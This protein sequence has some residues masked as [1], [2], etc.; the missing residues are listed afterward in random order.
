M[1]G[2]SLAS[3]PLP[4]STFTAFSCIIGVRKKQMQNSFDY[5]TEYQR[6]IEETR[7]EERRATLTARGE[8]DAT[9]GETQAPISVASLG[10]SLKRR[11]KKSRKRRPG[12]ISLEGALMSRLDEFVGHGTATTPTSM[13]HIRSVSSPATMASFAEL[14]DAEKKK[15]RR[16]ELTK[17]TNLPLAEMPRSQTSQSGYM[18]IDSQSDLPGSPSIPASTNSNHTSTCRA[19]T[20]GEAEIRKEFG[21]V[22]DDEGKALFV[23]VKDVK[24]EEAIICKIS[25]MRKSSLDMRSLNCAGIRATQRQRAVSHTGCLPWSASLEK[26]SLG[27][28][29]GSAG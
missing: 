12:S 2:C 1:G 5:A 19:V 20:S 14:V 23:T 29:D 13:K 8:G 11:G 22:H 18:D 28:E 26:R 27:C 4:P 9:F 24:S 7:L 6:E 25:R 15:A 17:K 3:Q 10:Y 21:A 16:A